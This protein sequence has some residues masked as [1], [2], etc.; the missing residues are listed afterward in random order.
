MSQTQDMTFENMFG[1][2]N[3]TI[4]PTNQVQTESYFYGGKQVGER[5]VDFD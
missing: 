3:N 2:I 1:Q 5:G 4:R